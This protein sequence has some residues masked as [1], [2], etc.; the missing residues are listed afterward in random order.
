MTRFLIIACC[1]LTSLLCCG[2]FESSE[3]LSS[4][5]ALLID[6]KRDWQGGKAL[7]LQA[8]EK[9]E[10]NAKAHKNLALVLIQEN[11]TDEARKHLERAVE[12]APDYGEAHINLSLLYY[13]DKQ[14]DK[15][16]EHMD[17]AVDAGF[18]VD[19]SYRDALQ[20]HR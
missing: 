9:D 10:K 16:I 13:A 14:Y 19:M 5:G 7:F 17:L 11:K 12:L 4:Q 3:E 15:A 2:C 18:P 1:C 8:L 6:L 20:E